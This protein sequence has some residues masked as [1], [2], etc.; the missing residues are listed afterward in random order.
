VHSVDTADHRSKSSTSRV[1]RTTHRFWEGLA[2]V[3][4]AFLMIHAA[5]SLLVLEQPPVFDLLSWLEL[6]VGAVTFAVD[7][8]FVNRV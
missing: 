4:G 3:G 2:V 1:P 8:W 5:S 6:G 7:A